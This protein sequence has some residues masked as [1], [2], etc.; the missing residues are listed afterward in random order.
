MRGLA[1][2]TVIQLCAL[3]A[4]CG[5]TASVV[6]DRSLLPYQYEVRSEN[7]HYFATLIP[8]E[9]MDNTQTFFLSESSRPLTDRK[10][11]Q[12]GDP[13]GK[14]V[15]FEQTERGVRVSQ[16]GLFLAANGLDKG[17]AS[18]TSSESPEEINRFETM[19]ARFSLVSCDGIFSKKFKSDFPQ[20]FD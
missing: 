8:I 14:I 7:D 1:M 4:A 2:V 3:A 15:T 5:P 19:G 17:S 12:G 11:I 18:A 16:L 13:A 9:S 20:L 6:C 10:T